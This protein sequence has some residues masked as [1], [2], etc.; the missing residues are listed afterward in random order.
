MVQFTQRLYTRMGISKVV[1]VLDGPPASGKTSTAGVLRS[2]TGAVT[3]TYKRLGLANVFSTII[4][5][6]FPA[7]QGYICPEKLRCD[8]IMELRREFFQRVSSLVFLSEIIYK[9]IQQLLILFLVLFS[10]KVVV[11][12]WFSLG[13]ANYLNLYLQKGF[14]AEYVDILIRFDVTFL[15]VVNSL[16]ISLQLI[17]IDRR[18]NKVEELWR[19]RGHLIPYDR[20]FYRLVHL[21]Y[22]ILRNICSE[23]PMCKINVIRDE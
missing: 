19:R 4:L 15:R 20:L 3:V 10:H 7:T 8:P 1:I 12:E 2:R 9:I 16:N 23:L 6:I 17:F 21:S 5:H 11:D 13:W 14:K 18:I 22:N